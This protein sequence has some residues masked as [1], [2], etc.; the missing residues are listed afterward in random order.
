[1]DGTSEDFVTLRPSGSERLAWRTSWRDATSCTILR[2][3]SGPKGAPVPLMG[4]STDPGSFSIKAGT[5]SD[6]RSSPE[7]FRCGGRRSSGR[8]WQ[9]D[10]DRS[11]QLRHGLSRRLHSP[12]RTTQAVLGGRPR[13]CT[14]KAVPAHTERRR[15]KWLG[16]TR[17]RPARAPSCRC[18]RTLVAASIAGRSRSR[19]LQRQAPQPRPPLAKLD[20][21]AWSLTFFCSADRP[22]RASFL[23]MTAE[24]EKTSRGS[25]FTALR[26][27]VV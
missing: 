2:R 22:S 17:S 15:P 20:E 26:D 21:T 27:S 10:T 14:E 11:R 13:H 5:R 16:G 18:K 1:M 8:P 25:R 19:R 7:H 23:I 6:L 12:A 4:A 3:F 9:V 24:R